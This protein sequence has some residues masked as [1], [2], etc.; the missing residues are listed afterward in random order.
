MLRWA[1]A[2]SVLVNEIDWSQ[3][4][5]LHEALDGYVQAGD[6]DQLYYVHDAAMAY[7]KL[8]FGALGEHVDPTLRNYVIE[9]EESAGCPGA[10][11]PRPDSWPPTE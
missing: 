8:P 6:C 9:L 10:P 2:A 7:F 11:W 5:G 1:S 3:Y 4:G